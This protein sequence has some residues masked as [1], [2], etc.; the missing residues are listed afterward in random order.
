M[1]KAK[2]DQVV[3]HRIEMNEKEREL[4]EAWVGG[5]IVKNAVTPLAI[6][7]GVGSAS[8]IGYKTAKAL[9]GWTDDLIDDIKSTP[10]GEAAGVVDATDG[11]ALGGL[12]RGV[13][14]QNLFK[15]GAISPRN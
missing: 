14:A 10:I 15:I 12:N 3:V 13:G 7:A 6:A 8:Y 4:L 2:P 5:S 1:P 11:V 9:A